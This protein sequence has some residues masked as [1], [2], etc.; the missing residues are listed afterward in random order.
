MTE[1]PLSEQ[2][3]KAAQ[4]WC[5][6]EAAASMLEEAKS[7]VLSQMMNKLGDIPINRAESTVKGSQEWADYLEKMIEARRKANYAKVELEYFRMRHR[8]WIA[9]DANNRMQA[10]L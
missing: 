8:E 6:E 5:D 3:L 10:R 9:D 2:Y 1:V 4:K 7:A